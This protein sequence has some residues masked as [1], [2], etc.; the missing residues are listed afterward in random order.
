MNGPLPPALDIHVSHPAEVG[1]ARRAAST[2]AA[3]VGLEPPVSDKIALVVSEL[4]TNLLRHA[5]GGR[6]ILTPLRAKDRVGIQVESIDDGPGIPNISLALKDGF[7]T[8]GGFGTGLG[9]I[10]RLMDELT[11]DSSPGQ[12]THIVCSKWGKPPANPLRACPLDIG[13]AT[14]PKPG[15]EQNGDSFVIARGEDYVLVGVIDGL[16]HGSPAQQAAQ[17]ARRFVESHAE[18][19][20]DALFQGADY[21]CHGTRGCVMAL[22]RFNW[23]Q[24]TMRF[25]SVGNIEAR[26][27]G[28][29]RPFS[30][31][32]RRGII[33]L[34]APKAS[35][36]EHE[37]SRSMLVLHSDGVRSHWNWDDFPGLVDKPATLIAQELLGKL[38]KPEDD[39][40]V[41]VVK[42]AQA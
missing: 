32:V 36:T 41:L 1:A 26:V 16:G 15:Y 2:L 37:W 18:Q 30:F 28:A 17:A 4:A 31:A 20:L 39:A 14:R 27:V 7:S 24:G 34:N 3:E 35:V 12:G 19:P 40:T 25:G 21:A 29:L 22:A 9:T 11:I 8:A 23:R 5:G 33:G 42:G 38:A 6:L 10:H 13:V